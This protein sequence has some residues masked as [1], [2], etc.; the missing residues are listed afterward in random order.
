MARGKR[1]SE[2]LAGL[3]ATCN[4]VMET[5]EMAQAVI[6]QHAKIVEGMRKLRLAYLQ[7]R[8]EN[9][10]LRKGNGAAVPSGKGKAKRKTRLTREQMEEVK[11]RVAAFI[12]IYPDASWELIHEEVENPYSSPGSLRG[13]MAKVGL[14]HGT[15]GVQRAAAAPDDNGEPDGNEEP[16]TFEPAVRETVMA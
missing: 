14:T 2:L 5:M 1:K 13:G 6:E 10:Q 11:A 4:E 12:D 16:V 9:I 7:T 15:R 3:E 8:G